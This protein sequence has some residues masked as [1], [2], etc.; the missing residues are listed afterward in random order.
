MDVIYNLINVKRFFKYSYDEKLELKCKGR[1]LPD[2]KIVKEGSSRGKNYKRQFNCDIYTRNSWI[3]GCNRKIALFCFPCVLFGGDK[4]W[5]QVGVIDLVHLSDKIKKHETSK[6]HLHNQMEYAL[7]GS[8][9]IKEPLDSAYWINIQKFNEA[10]TKNRYVLSKIIDCIKFCSVFELAL[11]GHDETQTSDNPGIF[12]GLINFTAELDKTLAQHLEESTV[13]KGI[14]K[15]IQNDILDC[16]LKLCQDKIL[17]EIRESPYLAVMADETTD[18]SAKS[19]MV[20]VFRYCRNGAPV[21]RFWT[22]LVPS[23]LNADTLSK[24][25]FSVLDPILE[26][27]NN[28]LIA[29]SYDGEAVMCGQHAGVQARIK[30]KYPF[31]HFVH[32]YAHQLNLI[33]SKACSENSQVRLFFGNLN[34]IPTFF[35]NSPQRVAVLDKIVQKKIPHGAPT[36]WNFNIRTVNVVFEHRSS[37]IECMEE[38][39]ESF[40]KAAVCS[41]AS[42]IRRILVDQNFVFWLTFFHR[43]MPQV[44]VLYNALQ[45][46]KTDPLEINKKVT[47]FERYMN[48]VRNSIDDTIDQ[49]SSLCVEPL[50]TKMLW[51]DNSPVGHRRASIEVCDIIINCANDRFAFKNHL[52]ATSLLYPEQFDNYCDNFTDDNLSLTCASYPNLDRERLKTEL[53]VIYF[54]RDCRDSNGAIPFLKFLIE[55]NLTEPFQ[56]TVK[57]L[58]ILITVPMSTAE[59]ESKKETV[60]DKT[61][62]SKSENINITTSESTTIKT[63]SGK[64]ERNSRG[65]LEKP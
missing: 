41:S 33:M 6:H 7:L 40:D 37:F 9:N 39:E 1:P 45:K 61:T 11:R 65:N 52:L 57:L 49:G 51:K 60:S 24:N 54:R 26:N 29:Q 42:S 32:C 3:C 19:Q 53:S 44:D 48:S 22:Y 64:L 47:D 2:I 14:S 58:Q 15:E 5:T 28:T 35:E 62:G 13:F 27:S 4:S 18:I 36:R 50:P 38:I 46:T 55:N 34:E 31:A 12:R 8:V 20:V 56:E 23:K 30:E 43:I 25:I 59:A 17:E 10:L 21:E 16:M 63:L